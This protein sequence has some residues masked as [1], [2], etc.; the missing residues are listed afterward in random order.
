MRSAPVIY[1]CPRSTDL[2]WVLDDSHAGCLLAPGARV[3]DG[4]MLGAGRGRVPLTR[5]SITVVDV[6]LGL[7]LLVVGLHDGGDRWTVVSWSMRAP[8]YIHRGGRRDTS[9]PLFGAHGAPFG[10][11]RTPLACRCSHVQ[12]VEAVRPPRPLARKWCC[13]LAQ[14][15][16]KAELRTWRDYVMP[17][18]QALVPDLLPAK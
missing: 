2:E 5:D 15:P 1:R 8:V 12:G 11:P 3:G 9:S 14:Q 10:T 17:R 6:Q 16:E 13:G 7:D 18:C 4:P